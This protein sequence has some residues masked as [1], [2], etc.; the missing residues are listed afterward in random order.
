MAKYNIYKIQIGKKQELEKKLTS[1]HVGLKKVNTKEIDKFVF[2]FYF[3]EKPDE[4]DIWWYKTYKDFFDN[5]SEPKNRVNFATLI[6]SNENLCYAVSLGKSH[7]YLKE[8]C[9]LD[10]GLNLGERIVDENSIKIKHSKFY[11]RRQNKTITAYQKG[12]SLE[13]DSGESTHYLK[14]DTISEK[15]WGKSASFGH[16]VLFNL[17]KKP[18]ELP[19]LIKNIEEELKKK[20]IVKL[21]KVDLVKD[22][23]ELESLDKKLIQAI[24]QFSQQNVQT[25]E[26]TFS[27][28]DFIFLD[29]YK[30]SFYVKGQKNS[31]KKF[32]ELS[33]E[34]FKNF[35]NQQNINLT[36]DLNNLKVKVHNEHGRDYSRPLKDFLDFVDEKDR[37]C[38]IDG[39]WNQ[40]NNSYLEF[41]QQEVDKIQILDYEE[42]FNIYSDTKEEDFNKNRSN[43]GFENCDKVNE[44]LGKKFKVEKMDLFK[45]KALYFVKKGKPQKL[46]YV[47]DQAVNTI[48][49][50]QNNESKIFINNLEKKV[51]IICLWLLIDKK[52][53]IKKLSEINSL[54]FQMKLTD[55]RKTTNDAGYK[56]VV[57]INYIQN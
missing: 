9:D 54:I 38:L 11:K 30:Y 26:F 6:I 29:K 15:I 36:D 2:D 13:Y 19:I 35:I 50:L 57:K 44:T 22:E 23:R 24:S 8:F 37:Y 17:D 28:I 48:K 40:F 53:K 31:S 39:K 41:L 27:G 20:P 4:I 45:D 34:N 52:K 1:D 12:S 55:F 46:N 14:A 3:S 7:F 25:D 33:L 10:F 56:P 47:I 43:D 16:S 49:L 51:D 5:I 32:D 42:N 18:N 21:P